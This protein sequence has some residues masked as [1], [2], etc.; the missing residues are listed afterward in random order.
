MLRHRD[1]FLAILESV[2]AL[3]VGSVTAG[4]PS[5]VMKGNNNHQKAKVI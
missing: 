1:S 3:P 5:N 4:L 2:A